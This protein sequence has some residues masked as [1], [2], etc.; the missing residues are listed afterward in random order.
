MINSS[1]IKLFE[2]EPFWELQ[3]DGDSPS[4]IFYPPFGRAEIRAGIPRFV[5]Q[6]D[7]YSEN[8]GFQW[9]KFAKTQLDSY[10]GVNLT[11][12]RFF[13]DTQWT[14]EELKGKRVLEV[15]SGAGRFTE[16]LIST[17]ALVYSFDYSGAVEANFANHAQVDNLLLFQGSVY[18][19]PFPDDFFDFVFC[20]G[21]LQHT[22]DPTLAL[23]CMVRK[24]KPEGEIAVDNYP[25]GSSAKRKRPNVTYR[26][27]AK[28]L[29]FLTSPQLF[30]FVW[31]YHQ[32]WF[33]IDMLIRTKL[34]PT[35]Y[36]K[37]LYYIGIPCFNY[38]HLIK[39]P[40]KQLK[41]WAILDTFD[42]LGAKYD[43]PVTC[44]AFQEMGRKVNMKNVTVDI[45]FNGFVLK[46][47]GKV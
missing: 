6:K 12:D 18:E 16:I 9:K 40:Y 44:E 25:T 36:P 20:F 2:L 28:R 38:V 21:V 14:T 45:A 5:K 33:P 22:P 10:S 29:S 42:A 7:N 24:M 41:E 17:G 1:K 26:K 30:R 46:G 15:G 39:L 3:G 8:F 27:V 35:I 23:Q 32:F 47:A 34:P 11:R 4:A 19:I 43:Y 31:F 37:V 13:K